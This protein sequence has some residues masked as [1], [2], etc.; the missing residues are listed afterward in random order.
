MV[1]GNKKYKFEELIK[2]GDSISVASAN[3]YSLKSS[4]RKF[5]LDNNLGKSKDL[6]KVD[7]ISGN[8]YLVTRIA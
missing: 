6:F 3:V 7:D 4:L 1:H 2:K 8:N 5:A